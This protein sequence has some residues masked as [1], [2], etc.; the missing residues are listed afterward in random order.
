MILA[1][2]GFKVMTSVL[3]NVTESLL[4]NVIPQSW[5]AKS[6]PSLKPLMSYAKD[7]IARVDMFNEW[8]RNG[9]PNVFWISGFFFTQSFFTGI[10]QNFAR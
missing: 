2:Q 9:T 6:Y 4:N 10:R 8:I 5:A 3:D 7:L 1:M